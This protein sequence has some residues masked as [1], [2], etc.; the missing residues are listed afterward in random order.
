MTSTVMTASRARVTYASNVGMSML[1]RDKN[2][3]NKTQDGIRERGGSQM[4]TGMIFLCFQ[5]NP[6]RM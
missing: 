2:Y 1:P 5:T 4:H 6:N 3:R